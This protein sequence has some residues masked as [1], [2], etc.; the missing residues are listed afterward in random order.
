M[1]RIGHKKHT[2]E[3]RRTKKMFYG[4][5]PSKTNE[6]PTKGKKKYAKLIF[7]QKPTYRILSLRISS[8]YLFFWLREQLA[9]QG[10]IAAQGKYFF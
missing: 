2:K 4:S 5:V 10:I 1:L 7:L 3:K 8:L 6:K 9:Q